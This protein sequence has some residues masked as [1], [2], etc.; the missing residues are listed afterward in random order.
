MSREHSTQYD[1]IGS[2]YEAVKTLPMARYP[3]QGSVAAVLGNMCGQSVLDLACGTGFYSRL[4]RR[5]GASRVVGVDVSAAMVNTARRIE[6]DHHLG[7][8]YQI[9][10][11][12][13]LP[14]MGSFDVVN[15]V[16]LLNYA[17]NEAAMTRMCESARRNL[18]DGGRFLALTQNPG[19]SWHGPQPTK[20][21]FTFDPLEPVP[22]GTRVRITAHLSNPVSFETCVIERSVYETA[23][24]QAGFDEF[25]WMALQVPDDAFELYDTGY[26]QDFLDNPP[27][28]L[29]SCRR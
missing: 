28:A 7:V 20:Y 3:E 9:A 10:D 14:T 11:A 19:F 4:A 6:A 21:G 13:N 15:A 2:E 22:M 29:L 18:A 8:R 16:Y 25:S 24:V 5:L 17:E 23:L 27:L 12:A 26:W 1:G